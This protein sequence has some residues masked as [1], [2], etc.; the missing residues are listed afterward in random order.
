MVE[1]DE[2]F[3]TE[4]L[5]DDVEDLEK[6]L[7]KVLDNSGDDEGSV[8]SGNDVDK[9]PVD[10]LLLPPSYLKGETA[11]KLG[12]DLLLMSEKIAFLKKKIERKRQKEL[13]E[14]TIAF[15][16]WMNKEEDIDTQVTE[17]L[18]NELKKDL[19]SF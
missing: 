5:R 6:D 17:L 15:S 9:D 12:C 2:E 3:D 19:Y 7:D 14:E 11:K 10:K 8:A 4:Q 13:D 18:E 1:K 16:K